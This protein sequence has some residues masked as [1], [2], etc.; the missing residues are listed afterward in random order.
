MVHLFH[1]GSEMLS[2]NMAQSDQSKQPEHVCSARYKEHAEK[3]KHKVQAK[4]IS[5]SSSSEE[6]QSFVQMKRSSKPPRAPF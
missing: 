3:R 2:L 1:H 4:Y 5:Q 6:D